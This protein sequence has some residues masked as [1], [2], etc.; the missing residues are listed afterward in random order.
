M[1]SDIS[2]GGLIWRMAICG[3]GFGFFQ[4]PNNVVMVMATPLHR[5]GAA[6]GMQSTGRLTGQTMGSTLVTI[7]F[8]LA[9]SITF[10]VKICIGIAIGFAACAAFFS[11]DRGLQI[12]RKGKDSSNVNSR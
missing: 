6:G 9:A 2:I 12:R 5:T 10:S 1:P 7:I 8:S 11:L 3:V 4:T